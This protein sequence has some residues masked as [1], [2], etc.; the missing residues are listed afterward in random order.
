[1]TSDDSLTVRQRQVL[2]LITSHLATRGL[3]PTRAEI[4]AALGFRSPNAAEEHL[5]AL[6]RKGA[7]AIDGSHRGLRVLQPAPS[8]IPL[9]GRVAAGQPIL[10]MAH[11]ER[12]VRIDPD[13]F[14]P[15]PDFLLRVAGLSMRDAGI[16]D[17]D[18]VAV[19]A[20][21]EARHGQIVVARLGEDATVKRL[22]RRGE[23]VRLLP[24]NPD[25]APIVIGEDGEPLVIEGVVVGV[26][27]RMDAR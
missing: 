25:F 1:M 27:R 7:I 18:W 20:G 3:P 13:L 2:D 15:P 19:R 14:R 6:E 23:R 5:R 17:G 22:E 4:A 26:I 21:R 8:G 9:I 16:L 11:V 12:H 24:A 10:A